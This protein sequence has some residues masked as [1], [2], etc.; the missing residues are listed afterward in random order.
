MDSEWCNIFKKRVFLRI[1]FPFCSGKPFLFF[2]NPALI[3]PITAVVTCAVF[4]MFRELCGLIQLVILA[5][6]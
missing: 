4:F 6:W 2:R 3:E 1:C 5:V